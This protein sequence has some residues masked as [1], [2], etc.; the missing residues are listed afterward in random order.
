MVALALVVVLGVATPSP[1]A[2]AMDDAA[3]PAAAVDAVPD[4]VD[5]VLPVLA[6]RCGE[7]HGDPR[8]RDG[9]GAKGG[10]RLDGAGGVM[11]G[12]ASGPAV[13]PG[14]SGRSPLV[15][16]LLLPDYD[17]DRMPPRGPA[18]P[19]D[20][21]A[22]LRRWIDGGAPLG[23]GLRWEDAAADPERDVSPLSTPR[24][25]RLE[26][27]AATLGPER[28]RH[29]LDVRWL[30]REGLTIEWVLPPTSLVRVGNQRHGRPL[31][32]ADLFEL[33]Q[34]TPAVAVL[35]LSRSEVTSAGLE[36]WVARLP[37][38][39][40][41]AV[42]QGVI[43][44]LPRLVS[45]DLAHTAV[46][47]AGLLPAPHLERLVLVGAAFDGPGALDVLAT[48][49]PGTE[50]FLHESGVTDEQRGELSRRRPDLVLHGAPELP[51][52]PARAAEPDEDGR[53]GRRRR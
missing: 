20:E 53:P 51:G 41:P 16:R 12:G 4:F 22:L 30:R 40:D 8:L 13:R 35:D 38:V 23:A 15:Q 45:L 31:R 1:A 27:L 46:G 32:D 6:T 43:A 33:S 18:V 47:P 52:A 34:R 48:L 28:G 11:A 39:E 10:L 25:Q 19:G 37:A 21:I 14:D 26:R 7:C 17:I 24:L 49:P 50:V 42:P 3:A 5:H 36:D 29:W 44:P 2:Q 9:K